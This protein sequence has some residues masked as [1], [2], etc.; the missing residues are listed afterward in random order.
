MTAP[1]ALAGC[2]SPPP[3]LEFRDLGTALGAEGCFLPDA[4]DGPTC[5]RGPYKFE[6]D[7]MSTAD[8][9]GEYPES[10]KNWNEKVLT[11]VVR[12]VSARIP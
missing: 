4:S 12:T 3:A 10:D 7:G 8:G 6:V 2:S 1:L 11:H 9:V 5:H